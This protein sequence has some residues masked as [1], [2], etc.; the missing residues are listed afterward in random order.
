VGGENEEVAVQLA[1]VPGCTPWLR[2]A[3]SP[4][5]LIAVL[6]FLL[7][8]SAAADDLLPT[9][10]NTRGKPLVD[11]PMNTPPPPFDGK[12]NGFASGF[13]GWRYNAAE[14][15]GHWEVADG[16]FKGAENPAV[17][18]PATASYGFDF[19]DVVIQCEVRMN[20]V[21]MNG[22]KY[23]YLNV[24]TTD[25]KDYVCSII[26]NEG[27]F[28]IQKD[29]N[30]HDGPD[31]AVPLAQAK[32]PLKLNEWIKVL[33]EIR[34]EEMCATV[35]GVSLTGPHPLIASDKHSVMFVCGVEGSVR[36]VKAWEGLP[37]PDWDKNKVKIV[38]DMA[39]AS[40]VKR[41]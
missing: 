2:L 4:M 23:R 22:R 37:N 31:K 29:D 10:M 40:A 16:A 26:L 15:G 24:R 30:D 38:A 18:H 27:G 7:T 21:P 1:S 41:K 13:K 8:L 20:D 32:L 12:S 39:K 6:A 11:Q 36:N 25:T 28:R 33:F 19:K 14:R 5:K 9:L 35:N 3:A 34:G 17:N